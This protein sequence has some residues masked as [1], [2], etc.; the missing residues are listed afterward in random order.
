MDSRY[1]AKL[2]SPRTLNNGKRDSTSL[3]CSSDHA[4]VT[5]SAIGFSKLKERK[6]EGLENAEA[7][8]EATAAVPVVDGRGDTRYDHH[9][10]EDVTPHG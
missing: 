10:L 7:K 3:A 8:V 4:V 5:L 1:L 2:S 9:L 6:R